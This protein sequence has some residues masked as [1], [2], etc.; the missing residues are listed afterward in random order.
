MSSKQS[1]FNFYLN[2]NRNIFLKFLI[3]TITF[4]FLLA[5][6]LSGQTAIAQAPHIQMLAGL[7]K[8]PFI[9]STQDK[10]M[11]LEIIKAAF[12]V[13]NRQ[14]HFTYLPLSRHIDVYKK[15]NIEGLITL[16]ENE[17]EIGLHLSQPYITY[18]NVVVTLKNKQLDIKGIDDLV[19]RRVASFQNATKF[20]GKKYKKVFLHSNSYL[21]L[22]DQKSQLSLL[23]SGRVEAIILDVNIFK[24]FLNE[25]IEETDND[26][27]EQPFVMH[28]IFKPQMYVAGF[29]SEIL[30]KSFDKGLETI[31][32]NGRYQ[33]IIDSYT[34]TIY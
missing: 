10:G 18:T 33:D 14:V 2:N 12:A 27:F 30:Q 31:K 6:F 32:Q 7:S 21:E 24:Y 28:K 20:L 5:V 19:D 23:F 29:N 1:L 26:V 25:L 11:Q 8:P 13:S 15:R 9:I 4:A 16:S 3:K 22:A 17:T 34:S